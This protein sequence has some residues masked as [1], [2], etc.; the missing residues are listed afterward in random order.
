MEPDGGS[1]EPPPQVF[2]SWIIVLYNVVLVSGE[3]PECLAMLR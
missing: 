1:R 2:F 3:E